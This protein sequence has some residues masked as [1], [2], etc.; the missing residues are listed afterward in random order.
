MGERDRENIKELFEKIT[1]MESAMAE[2]DK[3]IE[4]AYREK[5]V[6]REQLEKEQRERHE[7]LQRY[8][9]EKLTWSQILAKEAR[10]K[11]DLAQQLARA[12]AKKKWL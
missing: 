8:E 11:E 10:E 12:T 3:L 4:T 7:S 6:L 2:K 9:N 5:I 1:Q